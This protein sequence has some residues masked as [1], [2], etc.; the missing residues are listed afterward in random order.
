V[1]DRHR[2]QYCDASAE[3]LDHVTPR[4][5]GGTHSWENV[6]AACLRCNAVKRDRLLSE[7]TMRL[8][9]MPTAPP[10]SAWVEVVVGSIPSSWEPYLRNRQRRS[11]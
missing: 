8:R 11:A 4:S 5:R 3:T 9:R 1:R 7:T 2:C 10:P 6:V